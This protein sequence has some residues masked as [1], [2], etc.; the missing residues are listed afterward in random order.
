MAKSKKYRIVTKPTTRAFCKGQRT[1]QKI[2]SEEWLKP[3]LLA[4]ERDTN[5]ECYF[6][7]EIKT[8]GA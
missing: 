3:A 1:E 2:V 7:E 5:V 6:Y 4:V 8:R